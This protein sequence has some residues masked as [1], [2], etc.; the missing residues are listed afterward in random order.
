MMQD[1][2]K[3]TFGQHK[4]TAS[5][6]KHNSFFLLQKSLCGVRGFYKSTK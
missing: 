6:A 5:Q 1:K 4:L 3:N 2:N